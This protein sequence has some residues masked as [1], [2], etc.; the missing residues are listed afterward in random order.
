MPGVLPPSPPSRRRR[1]PRRIRRL[2]VSGDFWFAVALAALTMVILA[3]G[4][5]LVLGIDNPVQSAADLAR[6]G[7]KKRGHGP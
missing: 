6:M 7:V 2:L 1:R 4:L 5:T 3:W